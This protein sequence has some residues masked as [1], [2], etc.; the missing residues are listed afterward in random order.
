MPSGLIDS[1]TRLRARR[2]RDLDRPLQR[3]GHE[4]KTRRAEDSGDNVGDGDGTGT[5]SPNKGEVGKSNNGDEGADKKE[6]AFKTV[7]KRGYYS[8]GDEADK[9]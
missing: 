3:Y 5:E 9:N 8:G 2:L 1:R 7:D 6:V 4:V